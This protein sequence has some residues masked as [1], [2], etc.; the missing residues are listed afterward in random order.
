MGQVGWVFASPGGG[1]PVCENLPWGHL[2]WPGR[3]VGSGEQ[4]LG[5]GRRQLSAGTLVIGGRAGVCRDCRC[6]YESSPRVGTGPA[7]AGAPPESPPQLLCLG[8]FAWSEDRALS[9]CR[10][11]IQV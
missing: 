3:R 2:A 1:A 6:G 11:F 7:L 4:R 8:G 5:W 10:V 9:R